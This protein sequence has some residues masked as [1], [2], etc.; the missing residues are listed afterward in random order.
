MSNSLEGKRKKIR[1]LENELIELTDRD[2]LSKIR[3]INKKLTPQKKLSD[4]MLK[5]AGSGYIL[6]D[7]VLETKE[8]KVSANFKSK[9]KPKT[10]E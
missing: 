3:E 8:K 7:I 1:K 10:C 9:K 5:T 4:F 2:K 6:T